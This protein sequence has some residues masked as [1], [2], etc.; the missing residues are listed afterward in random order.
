M[1]RLILPDLV[2]EELREQEERAQIAMAEDLYLRL[3]A[4]EG[5]SRPEAELL[6]DAPAPPETFQI[7]P[8]QP[9][10]R[11]EWESRIMVQDVSPETQIGRIVVPDMAQRK[12]GECIVVDLGKGCWDDDLKGWQDFADVRVGDRIVIGKYVG[13]EI[14]IPFVTEEGMRGFRQY[15][16]LMLRDIMAKYDV[17]RP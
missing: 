12:T 15:R 8:F 5:L 16:V 13:Q 1:S 10:P 3:A 4:G 7:R 17:V 14:G 9:G 2:R 11:R 6:C